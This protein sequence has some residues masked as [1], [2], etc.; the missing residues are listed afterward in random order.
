MK[1]FVTGSLGQLGQELR[2]VL[3]A[4]TVW[5]DVRT[6]PALDVR[7][8]DITDE[9]TVRS[10]IER[11][12]PDIVYHCAAYTNVDGAESDEG[13]ARAV[14]VEG[15]RYV[16]ETAAAIGA[17]LVVISTD[18]VFDGQSDHP[19]TET[20]EPHPLSVYGQI[21]FDG[22][23]AAPEANSRTFIVRTAWL[24]G[25]S[26]SVAPVKNFPE[27][28]RWLAHER[29]ELRVVND[30]IGSPTFTKDLAAAI[31]QLAQTEEFGIWHIVNTGQASWYEFACAILKDD[32]E[33]GTVALQ[34]I[35]T[36]DYPTA[37]ER[38]KYSVLD[39]SKFTARFGP[40]RSWPAALAEYLATR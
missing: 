2:T 34:P 27:T 21:K 8:L 36:A 9:A 4:D 18:F 33:S 24:Y 32:I 10:M 13:T 5:T 37:A 3:P 12:K 16:A 20:D 22:E 40:L 7:A 19:Y 23:W 28:M 15:T 26:R 35:P 25:P 11:A 1:A 30:Q 6:E 38:P 17:K 14:N 31:S 29:R 39:T